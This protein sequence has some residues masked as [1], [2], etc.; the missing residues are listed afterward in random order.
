MKLIALF[1][2][3]CLLPVSCDNLNV[4][5]SLKP[6]I[7]S[8]G[9]RG[10]DGKQILE[11]LPDRIPADKVTEYSGGA[12]LFSTPEDYSK[13][14]YCL[15]NGGKSGKIRILKGRTIKEMTKNQIGDMILDVENAYFQ[16]LCC[17]LRGLIT[18]TS[19]W[20]LAWAIDNENKPYG[21]K[22]GTVFW[23]G[24]LNTYF[25]IDFRSGIAASIYTQ[26]FPF[27]HPETTNLFD[28]FSEIVYSGGKSTVSN[29][30][31]I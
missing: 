28:R 10:D 15:L 16:P 22:A 4:P 13:L 5:D 11:E 31:R 24:S 29:R 1:I 6:F 2:F 3:I 30:L 14:L 8:M 20:G 18:K 26:H 19:K 23:G 7:V 9:K 21:R 27:N 25:Y 17:D 12:G